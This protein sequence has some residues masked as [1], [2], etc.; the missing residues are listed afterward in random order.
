MNSISSV[1]EARKAPAVEAA[2]DHFDGAEVVATR[3]RRF[4]RR[5]PYTVTHVAELAKG[6]RSAPPHA[7][8]GS[9]RASGIA[10]SIKSS[11]GRP[12]GCRSSSHADAA[13]SAAGPE[14]H[15]SW[16]KAKM[17]RRA[18]CRSRLA[19]RERV[20]P[21]SSWY[22][23][24]PR[25]VGHRVASCP[26]PHAVV[27][28]LVVGRADNLVETAE[29]IEDAA[30]ASASS[31]PEQKSTAAFK[32]VGRGA[33]VVAAA[34]ALARAV[35]PDVIDP[36]S[37]RRPSETQLAADGAGSFAA[38]DGVHQRLDV[39]RRRARRRC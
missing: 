1:R 16:R 14:S 36:A 37:C 4:A 23:H 15:S 31:A 35:G 29:R 21:N 12:C 22:R 20:L 25:L 3:G 19:A 18:R 39:C 11:V 34:V 28:V 32:V 5:G 7:G 17:A 13:R 9:R 24:R 38:P 30:P 33:R 26:Q 2:A 27:G 10:S 8:A 6:A